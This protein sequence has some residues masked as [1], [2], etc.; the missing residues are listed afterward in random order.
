MAQYLYLEKPNTDFN[1]LGNSYN[2][3]YKYQDDG[4]LVVTNGKNT[5]KKMFEPGSYVQITFKGEKDN[6]SCRM[7]H[8]TAPKNRLRNFLF[9]HGI[10]KHSIIDGGE[11]KW[12]MEVYRVNRDYKFTPT[13]YFSEDKGCCL[14]YGRNP[15]N[16]HLYYKVG[17]G[18]NTKVD[19]M[20]Q[21]FKRL[22]D[23]MNIF[24][25]TNIKDRYSNVP[26]NNAL[27]GYTE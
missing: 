21:L 25:L 8:M 11:V 3:K 5:F 2:W 18:I 16:G 6:R 7:F 12:R 1:K 9:Y 22:S 20:K 10:G 27:I 26:H 14:I 24:E 13:I 23:D 4:V 19:S 15:I 17:V